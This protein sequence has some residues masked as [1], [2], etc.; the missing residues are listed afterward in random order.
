M[1]DAIKTEKKADVKG[2]LDITY[3]I[4]GEHQD[5]KRNI[6][7]YSLTDMRKLGT[8]IKELAGDNADV[9]MFANVIENALGTA[10]VFGA[11]TQ[12]NLRIAPKA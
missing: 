12:I 7:G 8:E 4:L 5:P 11:A 1:A 6:K 3:T 2:I 10:D 9:I